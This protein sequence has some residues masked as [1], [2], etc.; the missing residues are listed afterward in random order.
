MA[1]SGR[2]KTWDQLCKEYEGAVL[3]GNDRRGHSIL[4]QN[5]K[6]AEDENEMM[7]K[8]IVNSEWLSLKECLVM[9]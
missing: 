4:K 1:L 7:K 6:I 8:L 5:L 9:D 2:K 3:A